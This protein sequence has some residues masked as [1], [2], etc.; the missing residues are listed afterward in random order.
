MTFK[1]GLLLESVTDH[2]HKLEDSGRQGGKE[3]RDEGSL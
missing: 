1:S 2:A 3:K